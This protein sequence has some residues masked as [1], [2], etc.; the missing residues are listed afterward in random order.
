MARR[1]F[2]TDHHVLPLPAGHKFPLEKYRLLRELL[3]QDGVFT[4]EPAPLAPLSVVEL[5]HD[6]AYVHAFVA[7]ALGDSAMRRIGFPWSEAL[8]HRALAS[9]GSTLAAT[10]EALETGWGGTLAGGT[11]HAF[12]AEGSGFCVF[13]DIAVAARWL[14]RGKNRT[15]S[16][17]SN[18]HPRIK[19][20]AVID[21]D[22][23]QGDGTAH[24]FRDDPSV[25]TLS[26]HCRNNFP[27]RKQTSKIDVELAAGAAD[28]EYL[29]ALAEVLP[30]VWQFAPQLVFYQAGVDGLASDVLGHLELTHAGLME[31]DRV[32]MRGVR[33][34]GVP[35][36][37]TLGGGYSRP[38]ELTAQAH[39]NTFRVARE[40]LGEKQ[41]LRALDAT[42]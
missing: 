20:I 22:V 11:H 8:V 41:H 32:V 16:D 25:L 5:V 4:L 12:A 26:V 6:P 13:N 30:R 42:R 35:F 14:Q 37:I 3:E 33:Q 38:I 28:D 24:I 34:L 23:H 17:G 27:L 21:L 2:Y 29:R 1:L 36:V 7:G 31:R 40:V 15:D 18:P 9:V 39:A 19:R 10:K